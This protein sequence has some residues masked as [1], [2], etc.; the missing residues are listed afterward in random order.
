[1]SEEVVS[2]EWLETK[3]ELLLARSVFELLPAYAWADNTARLVY[4]KGAK[5][6]EEQWHELITNLLLVAK[7]EASK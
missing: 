4:F 2:V 5:E 7:K 3:L 1:M 6:T